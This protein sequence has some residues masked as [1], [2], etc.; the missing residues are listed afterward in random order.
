[1]FA[2]EYGTGLVH[3]KMYV[4]ATGCHRTSIPSLFCSNSCDHQNP[5]NRAMTRHSRLINP[6]KFTTVWR[7]FLV[8]SCTHQATSLFQPVPRNLA[9]NPGYGILS[10][11][12]E[13]WNTCEEGCEEL[14]GVFQEVKYSEFPAG[15]NTSSVQIQTQRRI[16]SQV[17]SR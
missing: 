5:Q 9:R 16:E 1:M 11:W 17:V 8:G 13:R 4:R 10:T 12:A 15:Q 2:W 7:N 3:V 6:W 14:A